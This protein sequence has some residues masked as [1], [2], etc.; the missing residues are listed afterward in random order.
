M[1]SKFFKKKDVAADY[2]YHASE[3]EMAGTEAMARKR[4][5]EAREQFLETLAGQVRPLT[6]EEETELAGIRREIAGLLQVETGRTDIGQLPQAPADSGA[7]AD[8]VT[9]GP[10]PARILLVEDDPDMN[11]LLDFMLKHNRFEA[12]RFNDGR[13]ARDWILQHPPVDLISL[14]IMLPHI[15]GLQL[16]ATIRRQPGWEK[17]PIMV[18]SSKSDEPTVQRA[19]KLGASDY[20]PKPFQPEVYIARIKRLLAA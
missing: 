3:R 4:G 10:A 6:P 7:Y 20:L 14:D 15:D 2:A 5:L 16:V 8:W 12:I 17:V 18:L 1:F 19:L 13:L 11:S 9:Q